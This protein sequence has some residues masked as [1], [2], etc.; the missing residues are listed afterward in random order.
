[1]LNKKKMTATP[2]GA[3]PR[4]IKQM[5]AIV[6]QQKTNHNYRSLP[7]DENT[8]TIHLEEATTRHFETAFL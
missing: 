8:Y 5:K 6:R 3:G 1:V 7:T 4:E 2:T